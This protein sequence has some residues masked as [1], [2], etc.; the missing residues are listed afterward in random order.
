MYYEA[1]PADVEANLGRVAAAVSRAKAEGV[2]L[3]LF[4]ELFLC[5]YDCDAAQLR[6][7]SRAQGSPSLQAAA[8]IA[9]KSGVCVALPY[10]EAVD[11]AE[12]P[13]YNACAVFDARGRLALNYRKVNLWGPWEQRTFAP[14]APDQ[15]RCAELQLASGVAVVCGVLICYDV[16][17]YI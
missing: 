5:G 9:R 10:C 12:G 2:E 1:D 16:E 14:G 13:L 7:A 8:Q 6:A 15:L 4:P 17:S 11:G 3:V